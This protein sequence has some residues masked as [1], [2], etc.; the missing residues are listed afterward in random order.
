MAQLYL[1]IDTGGQAVICVIPYI[2]V[3]ISYTHIAMF[4]SIHM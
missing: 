3:T 4:Q 1:R 2:L